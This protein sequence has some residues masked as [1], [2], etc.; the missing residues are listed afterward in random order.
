MEVVLDTNAY[1]DWV[2]KGLWQNS[3][4][5]AD[6]VWIPTVVIGELYRGFISGNRFSVNEAHLR[7]VL[8]QP[9]VGI[10]DINYDVA[11]I[12]GELLHFLRQGGQPIPTNDIWIAA[13][14]IE[15]G[16]SL[17]TSDKH[18]ERLPQVRLARRE[19]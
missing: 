12:Y 6:R 3:I 14:C 15:R 18:F 7:E 4:V 1:S 8:N 2:R 5:R 13:A 10:I 16:A 9:V 17:L 11:R 19:T